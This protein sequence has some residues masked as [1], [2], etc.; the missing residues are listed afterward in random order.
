MTAYHTSRRTIVVM[1]RFG[2]ISTCICADTV[3][4]K[5][6]CFGFC[7]INITGETAL[8]QH[9]ALHCVCGSDKLDVDTC[10]VPVHIHNVDDVGAKKAAP[11]RRVNVPRA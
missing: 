6:Q 4:G 3:A 5:Q 11:R 7:V 1:P 2:L 8:V 9:C 10:N